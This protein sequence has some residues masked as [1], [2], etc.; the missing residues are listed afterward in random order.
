MALGKT[1]GKK[2]KRKGLQITDDRPAKRP[3]IDSREDPTAI[4][5]SELAEAN[6]K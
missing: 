2:Q 4:A 1:L 3:D 5:R 6:A